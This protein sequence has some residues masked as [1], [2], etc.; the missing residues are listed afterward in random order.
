MIQ[1]V[2]RALTI[3]QAVAARDSWVGVREIARLVDLKVPTAQNILKTLAARGYL[4]FSEQFRGYRIGVVPLL[5][6]DKVD[7]IRRMADMVRPYLKEIFTQFGETVTFMTLFGGKVVVIDSIASAEPLTVIEPNRVVKDPHCLASGKLLLAFAGEELIRA[8]AGTTPFAEFGPNLPAN[9]E[10]F[11]QTLETVRRERYAEAINARAQGIGA[12]AVPVRGP[13]GS[14]S[15]ALACSA[16]LV[17]FG[18]GRRAE[19][20]RELER[21][22]QNIEIRTGAAAPAGI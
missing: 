21:C 19:V 17:R 8:Y 6:A 2:D 7:P 4:E 16:P 1:S 9:A 20:R 10:E 18:A 11:F 14:V 3:L 13:E 5:L 12:I 22:A 15:F